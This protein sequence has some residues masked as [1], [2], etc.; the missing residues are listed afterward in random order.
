VTK[1]I[2]TKLLRKPKYNLQTRCRHCSTW[3]GQLV[4]HSKHKEKLRRNPQFCLQMECVAIP[5]QSFGKVPQKA[6]S[7]SPCQI[8]GCIIPA[9]NLLER[10]IAHYNWR[11]WFVSC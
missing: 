7:I 6:R 4:E 10:K 8:L 5:I 9:N 3:D 1:E 11:P 2:A